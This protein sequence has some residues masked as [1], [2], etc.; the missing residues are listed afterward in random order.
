MFLPLGYI[1]RLGVSILRRL[2]D[3]PPDAP[4]GGMSKEVLPAAPSGGFKNEVESGTLRVSV[5]S[6]FLS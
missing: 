3:S 4:S 5:K 6:S 1:L 2:I